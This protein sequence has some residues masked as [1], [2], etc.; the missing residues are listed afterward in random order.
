MIDLIIDKN[1]LSDSGLRM[2]LWSSKG[3]DKQSEF[4][5]D[6]DAANTRSKELSDAGRDV[7]F[8]LG[9]GP[10]DISDKHKRFKI[11][12]VKAITAIWLDADY[13]LH[14]SGKKYPE[15]PEDTIHLIGQIFMQPSLIVDS[16]G[17]FHAYWILKEPW[18]FEND[19]DRK[20]A[21]RTIRGWQ[22]MIMSIWRK[23]GYTIDS[24]KDLARVLRVPGTINHKY[25]KEVKIYSRSNFF[26]NPSDFEQ[27]IG[28]YDSEATIA[29]EK[30]DVNVDMPLTME[31]IAIYQKK[32]L[33]LMEEDPEFRKTFYRRR[34]NMNDDSLS[35]YDAAL[36]RRAVDNGFSDNEIVHLIIT[37][38]ELHGGIEKV[39]RKKYLQDTIRFARESAGK[40]ELTNDVEYNITRLNLEIDQFQAQICN[41]EI[42]DI[43]E[44]NET[45]AML[46]RE[47]LDSAS[48]KFAVTFLE[49]KKYPFDPDPEFEIITDRG[50]IYLGRIENILDFKLFKRKIAGVV[51][52]VI[53][54]VDNKKWDKFA[55]AI[56]HATVDVD[57]MPIESTD[58]GNARAWIGNFFTMH[59]KQAQSMADCA[60]RGAPYRRRNGAWVIHKGKFLEWL[61][62][63]GI[64]EQ[65]RII[66]RKMKRA[67][68]QM[69]RTSYS[70]DKGK[71]QKAFEGFLI[72][73]HQRNSC[74]RYTGG[75]KD[76]VDGETD[77]ESCDD[78]W[79]EQRDGDELH[80]SGS[81]GTGGE[82]S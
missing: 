13:G 29:V 19:D 64:K 63:S 41:G 48:S 47:L 77:R 58:A 24:T 25:N 69:L 43:D 7:Y 5:S 21:Q 14:D 61:R 51:G 42:S 73:E 52:V 22:D 44:A 3:K 66:Y 6:I 80:E 55:Q 16:G 15:T 32:F 28:S 72:S 23:A 33:I 8:G 31:E 62:L 4:F 60:M 20:Q 67:G 37:F 71:T 39:K 10:S 68:Y 38:R 45:L 57:S 75:G 78:V 2:L 79:A 17:G 81:V 70:P 56:L 35:G 49:V 12:E 34:K 40:K 11:D 82:G 76:D 1:W 36:A 59:K 74:F 65:D 50:P 53:N 46:K 30:V 27:F 54:P 26:Y 9:L 18:V